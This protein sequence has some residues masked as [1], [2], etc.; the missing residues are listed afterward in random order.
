VLAL[1]PRGPILIGRLDDGA[2]FAA[3]RWTVGT[4]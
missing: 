3:D 4:G 2:V 1:Q